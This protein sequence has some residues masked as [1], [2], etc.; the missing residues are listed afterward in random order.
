MSSIFENAKVQPALSL[1]MSTQSV[2]CA[3]PGE[4][5]IYPFKLQINDKCLKPF[6]SQK[7]FCN[8]VQQSS[9]GPQLPPDFEYSL[10]QLLFPQTL[11][12]NNETIRFLIMCDPAIVVALKCV[13]EHN[14]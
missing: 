6:E 8:L 5:I 4:R 9:S 12:E 14:I 11:R 2:W 13:K 3:F 7:N 1:T 10:R